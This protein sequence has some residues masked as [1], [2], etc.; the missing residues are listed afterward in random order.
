MVIR[1]Y[2]IYIIHTFFN[3]NWISSDHLQISESLCDKVYTNW[4]EK[5]GEILVLNGEATNTT[6]KS[7]LDFKILDYRHI[8]FSRKI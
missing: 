6:N 5:E 7:E 4:S 2:I 3:E 8:E 1:I